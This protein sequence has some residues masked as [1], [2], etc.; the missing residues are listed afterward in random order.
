MNKRMAVLCAL[1]AGLSCIAPNVWATNATD[2]AHSTDTL[3]EVVVT[4]EFRRQNIQHVPAAIT[5]VTGQILQT[6]GATDMRALTAV[7]PSAQFVTETNVVQVFIRGVGSGIDSPFVPEPVI[8]NFN[9]IYLP[10]FVT[11]T[12]LFDL[13]RVEALP[14]PQ[15][16]LYGKG[17]LGGVVNIVAAKPARQFAADATLEVGN[18]GLTHFTGILN[19]PV[20]NDLALRIAVN[21]VDHDGYFSTGTDTEHSEA[22]RVS[23]L[24]TPGDAFSLLV[25]TS[26]YL[27][28]DRA[29]A[30]TYIPYPDPN[31]PWKQPRYDPTTA[32]FYPPNGYDL[33]KTPG[34]Y[35]A[36]ISGAR[37]IW[38]IGNV[39][40]TYI[41]SFLSYQSADI[42]TLQGFPVPDTSNIHQTT[43]E[44]RVAGS[45]SGPFSYIGGLY[46]YREPSFWAAYL[47]P[48]LGGYDVR[49]MSTGYAVYGQ[50]KLALNSWLRAT[51]GVRYSGDREYTDKAGDIYPVGAPPNFSEGLLPF[52]AHSKWSNVDWKVG[53]EADVAKHSLLY[54]NVQTGYDPAGYTSTQPNPGVT[55]KKQTLLGFAIGTKNRLL[56]DR[57]QLNDEIYYYDYKNYLLTAQVGANSLSFNVP[58]SRVYGDQ[59]DAIYA[60]RDDTQVNINVG[61]NSAKITNFT[62]NG[63]S[64]AG[65]QLPFAPQVTISA[66]AQHSWLL[67]NGS[68]LS[69][70]VHTNFQNGY[71]GLFDHSAGLHQAPFTKT[72]ASLTYSSADGHWD[73]GLWG[74]NLE[75][76]ATFG[77]AGATGYPYPFA[78]SG[79]IE[80]PRT[81][82]VRFGLHFGS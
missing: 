65:Y 76:T 54:A 22:V 20:S 57:L 61:L 56:D 8:T 29:N 1:L 34:R 62:V 74:R 23:A 81:F 17:A 6:I 2:S 37:A 12:A 21:K 43:Q 14:G 16:T 72:A 40:I 10:R 52:T 79:F 39:S 15:S 28:H 75:N 33:A 19:L 36:V 66:G 35:Q 49:N 30:A 32:F 13:A 60:F 55:L 44:L 45:P 82:G 53:L 11:G 26:Y 63:S 59:F 71:W 67:A 78:A 42:H 27:N 69:L 41:P 25:W 7:I 64:Y 51:A 31:D 46:W 18:Y 4:A 3:K 80:A 38:H 58:K 9:G 77:A 73:V 68:L 50:G 47:G 48:Y 24:Y 70:R 5:A